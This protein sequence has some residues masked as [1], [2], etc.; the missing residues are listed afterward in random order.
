MHE[1]PDQVKA[2]IKQRFVKVALA[3]KEEQK[4]PVG[5]DSAK[6]LGYDA[7]AIDSLPSSVTESFAGV[8]NPLALGEPRPGQ[9]AG[10]VRV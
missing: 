2:Q 1:T 8:G 4:F 9:T 3:P 5:P 6:R 10:G 7:K